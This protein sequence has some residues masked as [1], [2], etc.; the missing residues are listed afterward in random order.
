MK[1]SEQIIKYLI[2]DMSDMCEKARKLNDEKEYDR[3][4]TIIAKI[5][6]IDDMLYFLLDNGAPLTARDPG[7]L[8]SLRD[9]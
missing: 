6:W 1:T 3:L 4:H 8:T 2:S 9:F 7:E 5:S